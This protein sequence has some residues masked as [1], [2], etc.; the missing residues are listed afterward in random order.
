MKPAVKLLPRLLGLC[1]LAFPAR[2]SAHA[3]LDKAEPKVGSD[4]S[5]AP[6]EVRI[7]P[8]ST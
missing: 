7:W 3:A 6:A 5:Q 2:A 1:L 8:S 4:V